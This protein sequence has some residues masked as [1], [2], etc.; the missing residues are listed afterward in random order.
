MQEVDPMLGPLQ[1]NGGTTETHKLLVGSQA[2][3]AGDPADQFN[4]QIDQ[5][6]FEGIR[7]IGAFEA[8]TILLSIDD[9]S[10]SAGIVI[11][12]NPSNGMA[13]IE[14]PQTFGTTIQ[15]TVVE[16]GSGKL[17]KNFTAIAGTNQVEFSGLAN[18]VYI[19]KIVSETASSTHR[20]I[21]AK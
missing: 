18:G 20:L 13:N 14:I 4:D 19:L 1:N 2:Y 10:A 3:N 12:P 7:D 5:V 9:I 15:V 11:Y 6:V 17:V 8:Q 16:A 21:L